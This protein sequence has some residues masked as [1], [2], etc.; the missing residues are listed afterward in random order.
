MIGIG[1][2]M[3]ERR[4]AGE[5]FGGLA[6]DIAWHARRLKYR[7]V[8]VSRVGQDDGGSRILDWLRREHID[9][10]HVQTDPDL[11][12]GRLIERTIAGRTTVTLE[13]R[14]AFDSLQW[15]YDLED[16]AQRAEVVVFGQR[17]RRN[18]Q[19]RTTIDR[20]LSSCGQAIRVLDT[21]NQPDPPADRTE[22]LRAIEFAD[23]IIL[24]RRRLRAVSPGAASEPD[25]VIASSMQRRHGL[26][27][28]L[29]IGDDG[30]L[31]AYGDGAVAASE[32]AI[33][34]SVVSAATVGALH[35]L[36]SGWDWPKSLASAVRYAQF[37]FDRH[38][39]PVPD[40]LFDAH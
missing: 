21:T 32:G 36:L 22:T 1:E 16:V 11:P 34:H 38:D 9:H 26:V 23:A 6:L 7:G 35:G 31:R 27:F 33:S 3:V 25:D 5:S 19:S 24:D 4:S 29:L 18:S 8:P 15:D 20:F 12:T 28:V 13:A 40:N 14:S 17:A 39:E 10:E 37:V 30:R 2:A